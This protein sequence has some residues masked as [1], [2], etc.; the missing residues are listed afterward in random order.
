MNCWKRQNYEKHLASTAFVLILTGCVCL[1]AT[2]TYRISFIDKGPEPF[3]PGT[4]LYQ[5]T[6]AEFA[7]RSLERRALHGMN[8]VLVPE[9]APIYEPYLD[10]LRQRSIQPTTPSRWRNCVLAD[11]DSATAVE[12]RS[13]PFVRAVQRTAEVSYSIVQDANLS[14]DRLSAHFDACSPMRYGL[15]LQQNKLLNTPALHE[16][17]VFGQGVVVGIIDNGFRWRSNTTFRNA[18]V[19]GEVDVVY[20][21]SLTANEPNDVESQDGHGTLVF[22]LI[23]GMTPDTLVGVAPGAAFLLAKSEDMRGEFRREEDNYATAMEW[24]ERRGADVV[25]SSVGYRYFDSAQAETPYALLDGKSTFVAQAVNMAVAR[26]VVCVTAA[27]NDGVRPRS[28]ITPADADSVITVGNVRQ[29]GDTAAKSSSYGPTADGRL[30]PDVMAMGVGV[31]AGT[32]G[33]DVYTYAGGTSMSAPQIAG[34][35]ALLKSLHPNARSYEIRRALLASGTLYPVQDI[36]SGYGRPDVAKAAAILGP[37]LSPPFIVQEGTSL[38]FTSTIFTDRA[39]TVSLC[40]VGGACFSTQAS[41]TMH[42]SFVLPAA[43]FGTTDSLELR[44]RI[45]DA[46]AATIAMY[47]AD[48]SFIVTRTG[49]WQPCGGTLNS[50][51]TDVTSSTDNDHVDLVPMPVA[52]DA[53]QVAII[54]MAE[55]CIAVSLTSIAGLRLDGCSILEYSPNRTVVGLPALAPG[56]YALSLTTATATITRPLLVR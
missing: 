1:T 32:T 20:G 52:Q 54:G 14:I 35:C 18:H 9:D 45:T 6:L 36:V 47:P 7:P 55:Q 23:A 5:R 19:D 29:D 43:A 31:I 3:A 49:T 39:V 26:G 50:G 24:L 22:S 42:V 12:L 16:A 34:C 44:Y 13:L 56:W 11:I 15:S 41:S 40:I 38:R 21:D 17:G 27:G 37:C 53:R 8:P 25:T 33:S 30:K 51:I 10:A 2:E 46:G 4:A 28:L 48:T